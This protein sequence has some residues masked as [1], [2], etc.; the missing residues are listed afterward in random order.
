M[1]R[2]L[3]IARTR[4]PRIAVFSA[5]C[6]SW[7]AAAACQRVPLL[8]PTGSTITLTASTTALPMNGTTQLIAQVIEA[9]GTPPHSGTHVI[10][11]TTLGTIEPSETETDV[12][13]R[14]VVAFKAGNANGTATITASSGGATVAAA[15]AVKIA[16]G[17]AAVGGLSLTASPTTI[18]ASGGSST[19][20][21]VVSDIAGNV[22]PGVPVT[23]T[24]DNGSVDPSFATTDA[25]GRA[26]STLRTSRTAKVTATA[27]IGST[28]GT[29]T[30]PAPTKDVTVTVNA[31][32]TITVGTVTPPTPTAGQ[33]VSIP[34][35]YSTTGSPITSLRVDWGD[36]T[37]VQNFS[38]Q[39]ASI[40]H[41][42]GAAGSYLVSITGVD[43]F[44]DT[45][46]TSAAVTVVPKPQL[47][48]DITATGTLTAGSP[49]TFNVIAAPTTGNAITS[50]T[51]DFGDGSPS[52]T[53]PGNV[54]TAVHTYAS[55]GTYVVTATASDSSGA[56]GS[57]S[58]VIAVGSGFVNASFTSTA[59]PA[60]SHTVTFNASTSTASSN[61]VSYS[62][63]FGDGSPAGSG[64]TV[65][66]DF[67]AAGTKTVTLTVTDSAGRVGTVS[68]QVTAP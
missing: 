65:T 61:I 36:G 13:G 40:S 24:T 53:L 25:N 35:T 56:T 42:F 41:R 68:Q 20:A 55:S 27:G 4:L 50:V 48:V 10:F 11:T 22:L 34:L 33:T 6:L 49:V 52:T 57:G 31:T 19:I 64:V 59:G 32:N 14:A 18:A 23:F 17:T 60:A 38:G 2:I 46:T 21:A 58:T 54:K 5:I 37:G 1:L 26:T 44:G 51:I 16:V 3:N 66:H 7:L 67:A 63:N 47:V 28:S 43:S 45:S 39:P 8:A 62:W 30:T 12:N 15:N 9:G 29:T